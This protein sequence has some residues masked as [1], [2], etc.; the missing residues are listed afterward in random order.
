VRTGK[1]VWRFYTIPGPGESGHDT[2]KEGGDAWKH[3]GGS[4]WLTGSYDPALNMTYWG[5]GNPGPGWAPEQR[6]GDNLYSDSVVAL[7]ADTGTLKWHFQFTPHDPYDYDATQIPVLVDATWK[8]TPR[9]LMFWGNRNGFFYVLDRRTGE[10]LSGTPFAG[11]NWASGLDATGRPIFTRQSPGVATYPGAAGATN[12][13]SPSYSPRT[14]LFYLSTWEKYGAV[15]GKSEPVVY[16]SGQTFAGSNG[17]TPPGSAPMPVFRRGPINTWHEGNARGRVVALDTMTGKTV[18]TFDMH[19]VATSGVLTTG[20]DLV[21]VGGREGNFQ[22]LAATDGALLWKINLGG[23]II[24]GPIT[25]SVDGRQHVAIA[26]G[27]ALF[28]FGLQ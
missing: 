7:D 10:F 20:S 28:V 24:A 16:R 25:Y 17:T 11:I 14:G 26:A 23:E 3:G 15:F 22:A 9:T 2:W 5:V 18:W 8:G 6:P 27:H 19:D 1:E 4:V 12:W 13:W 21:F